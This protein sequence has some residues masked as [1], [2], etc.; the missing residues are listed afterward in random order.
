MGF[1][2]HIFVKLCKKKWLYF[3]RSKFPA[4]LMN[5]A[6]Q[7]SSPANSWVFLPCSHKLYSFLFSN[8]THLSKNMRASL[9]AS[10]VCPILS[11]KKQKIKN[12]NK[13]NKKKVKIEIEIKQN[14][15]QSKWNL[16]KKKFAFSEARHWYRGKICLCNC[17]CSMLG[18]LQIN[19]SS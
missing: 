8:C 3:L 12:R 15:K 17:K 7:L 4:T 2:N 6:T 11:W 18:V 5:V 1:S 14:Q 19:K 13:K 16:K 9:A 10:N